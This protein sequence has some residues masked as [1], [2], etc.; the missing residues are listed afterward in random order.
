M[1]DK[2]SFWKIPENATLR[3]LDI[4]D[5]SMEWVS[6]EEANRMAAPKSNECITPTPMKKSAMIK[7]FDPDSGLP[8]GK[9]LRVSESTYNIICAAARDLRD[10]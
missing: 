2:Y 10:K 8:S 5:S 4:Q 3:F 6:A 9:Y 7:M 1:N